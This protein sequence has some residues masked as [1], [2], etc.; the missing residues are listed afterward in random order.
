MTQPSSFVCLL[1]VVVFGSCGGTEE[2]PP[3]STSTQCPSNTVRVADGCAARCTSNSECSTGCCATL[4][5]GTNTAQACS[6]LSFCSMGGSSGGGA[7]AGTGA[8]TLICSRPSTAGTCPQ[9]GQLWCGNNRCCPASN[10]IWWNGNCYTST[11]AA[12]QGGATAQACVQC[13][14]TSS[15]AGGGGASGGGGTGGCAYER[16][17]CVSCRVTT[18]RSYCTGAADGAILDCTNN[19]SDDVYLTYCMA[20]AGTAQCSCGADAIRAGRS[21][22]TNQLSNGAWVCHYGGSTRTY[23]VSYAEGLGACRTSISVCR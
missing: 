18:G 21:W 10:P 19:C 6:P 12:A 16:N 4:T 22:G 7:G 3:P 15:G 20:Q 23:A 1:L 8:G 9:L 14:A 17:H 13:Q 2:A 5:N 11:Q